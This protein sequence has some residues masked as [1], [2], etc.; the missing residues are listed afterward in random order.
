MS[1]PERS[2]V[3]WRDALALLLALGVTAVI[4]GILLQNLGVGT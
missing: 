4:V 2:R 1:G 3:S